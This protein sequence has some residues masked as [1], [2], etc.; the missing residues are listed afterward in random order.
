MSAYVELYLDQG[1]TFSN[2][3][4][5][6]NDITNQ[7]INIAGYS[8]SSQ[9]RRSYYSANISA[10]IVCTI[11]NTS[12]G[13]IVMSMTPANTANIKPGRYVFDV[14]VT[15]TTNVISKILEGT[16]TVL[17]AVTK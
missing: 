15:D 2:I 10:N 9:M 13:E 4:N 6:T 12:N 14:K 16:I 3:I 5:L 7:S 8:V 11:A 17:P 1:T